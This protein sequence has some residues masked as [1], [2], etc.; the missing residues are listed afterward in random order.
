MPST[1]VSP[2]VVA[3]TAAGTAA[4]I[5]LMIATFAHIDVPAPL[6]AAIV[7]AISSVAAYLKTDPLRR[8]V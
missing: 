4:F 3:G 7:T 6:V 8:N 2:K 1:P 5:V